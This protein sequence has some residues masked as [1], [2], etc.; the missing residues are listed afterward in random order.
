MPNGPVHRLVA[1]TAIGLT[2]AAEE[3]KRGE[4]T[5]KPLAVGGLGA[6][7]GTLPDVLE[8]ATN[9]NHRQIFHSLAAFAVI[10][11][12]AKKLYEWEPTTSFDTLLRAGL[13]VGCGAYL[14]HLGMD[15]LT[16]R[17]LPLVGK[18]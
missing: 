7:L 1:G 15:A 3:A 6:L 8:P 14:I 2:V 9:P 16:P 17:S 12:G 4:A 18:I 5:F 11:Y 10:G 13:L